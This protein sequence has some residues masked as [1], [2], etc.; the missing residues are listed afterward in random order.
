[1]RAGA[2]RAN[3]R[4]FAATRVLL[5]LPLA[6]VP[7]VAAQAGIQTT[8]IAI[9]ASPFS[10]GCADVRDPRWAKQAL[11]LIFLSQRKQF[12]GA[13]QLIEPVEIEHA[14]AEGLGRT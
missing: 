7:L 2:Q 14:G 6:H 3:N 1:M 5:R 9:S 12:R 8:L 4:G 13:D 10:R 11:G